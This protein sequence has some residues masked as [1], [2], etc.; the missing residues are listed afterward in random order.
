M[1]LLLGKNIP[2]GEQASRKRAG[3]AFRLRTG[4]AQGRGQRPH[5]ANA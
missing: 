1:M 3:G 5:G 4:E 2:G